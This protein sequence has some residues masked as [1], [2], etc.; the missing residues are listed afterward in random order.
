MILLI[1]S[2]CFNNMNLYEIILKIN[3]IQCCRGTWQSQIV[4]ARLLQK[5]ETGVKQDV[6]GSLRNVSSN[7]EAF[8][9][10][11][12]FIPC[13]DCS[14]WKGAVDECSAASWQNVNNQWRCIGRAMMMYVYDVEIYCAVCGVQK[15]Q[16]KH[17]C[18]R[19]T[20]L[21]CDSGAVLMVWHTVWRSS[22]GWIIIPH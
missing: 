15:R 11:R 16:L 20:I 10:R 1:I 3:I 17:I 5:S 4:H 21:N 14:H 22:A 19:R 13:S 8:C 9:R 7:G 2:S 6:F 12:Q 18:Y